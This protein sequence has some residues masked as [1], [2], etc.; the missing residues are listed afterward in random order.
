[1]DPEGFSAVGDQD[2]VPGKSGGGKEDEHE[3]VG[4]GQ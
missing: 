4:F 2:V 1:M 3:E